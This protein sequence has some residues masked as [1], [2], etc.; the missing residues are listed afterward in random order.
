MF[1][2]LIFHEIT[3]TVFHLP[4][5]NIYVTIHTP[6]QQIVYKTKFS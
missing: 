6:Y 4:Y 3:K 5:S 1:T 2:T